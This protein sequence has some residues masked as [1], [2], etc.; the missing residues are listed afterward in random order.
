M[1]FQTVWRG[2]IQPYVPYFH[3]PSGNQ[4]LLLPPNQLLIPMKLGFIQRKLESTTV[5]HTQ[6][7]K[8]KP[9]CLSHAVVKRANSLQMSSVFYQK[10][11]PRG[12]DVKGMF[13]RKN[14][15]WFTRF[16]QNKPK[17]QRNKQNKNQC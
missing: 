12:Q 2:Y 7:R 9:L 15:I 16:G 13:L 3:S 8:I 5:L 10:T 4:N 14:Q 1:F 6:T 17:N 11:L